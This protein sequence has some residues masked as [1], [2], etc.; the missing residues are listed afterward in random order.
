[1][2]LTVPDA[3]PVLPPPVDAADPPSEPGDGLGAVVVLGEEPGEAGAGVTDGALV[4]DG[5]PPVEPLRDA[6]PELEPPPD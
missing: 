1:L 3:A 5:L 4:D 2:A 6:E